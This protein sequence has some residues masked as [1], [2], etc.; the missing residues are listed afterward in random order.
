[1]VWLTETTVSSGTTGDQFLHLLASTMM[2]E[3]QSAR[4]ESFREAEFRASGL[5]YCPVLHAINNPIGVSDPGSEFFFGFGH[6]YHELLQKFI[7]EIKR[8]LPGKAK[9]WGDWTCNLCGKKMARCTKP[10]T[11]CR[12][13]SRP[14]VRPRLLRAGQI[15]QYTEIDIE[16]R[17]LTGHIDMILR[18]RNPSKKGPKYR[19]AVIDF[20]T[21]MFGFSGQIK[22]GKYPIPPNLEQVRAYCAILSEK[23]G[24]SISG[25]VLIYVDRTKPL[26]GSKSFHACSEAFT[27]Q[28]KATTLA[29]LNGVSKGHL[30]A[31]KTNVAL[32][33]SKAPDPASVAKVIAARPCKCRADYDSRMKNAFY[34]SDGDCPLLDRCISKKATPRLM[35][36]IEEVAQDFKAING[37][38]KK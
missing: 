37:K 32:R 20:K 17:G 3:V 21:S 16:Y 27:E 15:W 18:Y 22:V 11:P 5:P 33:S 8:K 31:V 19:Y 2:I 25:F 28:T 13:A 7:P 24:M 38:K 14:P 6:A 34:Y 36:I 12:C 30:P 10:K 23:Y 1:M 4:V 9:A 29:Y 35:E 26:G